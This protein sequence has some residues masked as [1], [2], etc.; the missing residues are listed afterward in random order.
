MRAEFDV[1]L[2]DGKPF[3]F[4][5]GCLIA[6]WGE[7]PN[8]AEGRLVRSTY[9]FA[10]GVLIPMAALQFALALGFSSIFAGGE[11]FNDLL[12][13]GGS[14][15]P[16][17]ALCQLD[18]APSLRALWLLIGVAHLRLAWVLVELD[19]ARA[20]KVGALIC[21]ALMTLFIF[22]AALFVD[23][24]FVGLQTAVVAIEFAALIAAAR[25][26]AQLFPDTA[27]EMAAG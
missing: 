27:R 18:A 23:L 9:A 10:L 6:A 2:A 8:H 17:L 25:R 21:A 19:W 24:T 16:L 12:L 11:A 7:M 4:A 5:M 14:Q 26:H 15:N 13:V 20:A 22:M 1:A 3:A